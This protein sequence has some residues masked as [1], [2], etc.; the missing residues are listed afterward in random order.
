MVKNRFLTNSWISD[1]VGGLTRAEEEEAYNELLNR[2]IANPR[3]YL[4]NLEELPVI[5][6]NFITYS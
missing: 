3:F 4:D 5:K 1:Q 2:V 6:F